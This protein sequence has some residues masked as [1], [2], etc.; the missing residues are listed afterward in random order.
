MH[1]IHA[2]V[3][4]FSTIPC[5]G[6]RVSPET[7]LCGQS[8]FDADGRHGRQT[9]FGGVLLKES[10]MERLEVAT[11]YTEHGNGR[12]K[13]RRNVQ[14]EGI[15]LWEVWLVSHCDLLVVVLPSIPPDPFTSRPYARA[16]A[17]KGQSY[18]VSFS[19]VTK[20]RSVPLANLAL[21]VQVVSTLTSSTTAVPASGARPLVMETRALPTHQLF[22]RTKLYAVREGIHEGFGDAGGDVGEWRSEVAELNEDRTGWEWGAIS[23]VSAAV[24]GVFESWAVGEW[25]IDRHQRVDAGGVCCVARG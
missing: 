25:R 21:H 11:L 1:S 2:S 19:S 17:Q 7:N 24:D 12:G 9:V 14:E 18:M 22:A 10:I 8:V 4:R 15:R 5:L 6:I 16:G 3:F 23:G 20:S 13:E